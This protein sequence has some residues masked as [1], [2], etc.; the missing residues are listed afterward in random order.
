M[1]YLYMVSVSGSSLFGLL[2]HALVGP[3]CE[4]SGHPCLVSRSMLQLVLDVKRVL[5]WV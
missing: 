1:S 2:V 4:G 5:E 3:A